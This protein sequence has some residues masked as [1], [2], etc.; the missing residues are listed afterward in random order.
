MKIILPNLLSFL[1][2]LI[3]RFGNKVFLSKFIHPLV[4]AVGGYKEL[5]WD[6]ERQGLDETEMKESRSVG[7][8]R[9]ASHQSDQSVV[10]ESGNRIR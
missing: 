4:E 10:V 8:E 2:T 3:M 1:L 9:L 6:C 7:S 5:D